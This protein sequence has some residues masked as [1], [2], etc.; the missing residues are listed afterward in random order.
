MRVLA[1]LVFLP[2]ALWAQS[3]LLIS[4]VYVP[5]SAQQ[6]NAFVEIYNPTDQSIDLGEYYL[7]NYNSAYNIVTGTYSTQVGDFLVKFPAGARI[8]SGESRVVALYG[9]A[10]GNAYSKQAHWEITAEDENTPDMDNLWVGGNISLDPS[11]G[12]IHLFKWNGQ[13]DLIRDVDYMA[14]GLSFFKER[15]MDKSGVSIDGPDAD[16]TATAYR[17]DTPKASQKALAT[18][19]AGMSYQRNGIV[20]VA[21]TATEGNGLTG[22]DET[23]E[24]WTQSFLAVSPSP[25]SFSEVAGDG[26][27]SAVVDPAS[28][29]ANSTVTL[30]F[31]LTGT[32]DYVLQQ[33]ALIIP[34]SWS[35]SGSSADVSYSGDGLAPAS[36]S[37]RGDTLFFSGTQLTD[38]Q[39]GTI[40]IA[41]LQ[42]PDKTENSA[43]E[44]RTAVSG[45]R[46][47]P[48][49]VFPVVS[50]VKA[51]TIAD[52]QNNVSTYLGTQVTI[53]GVVALG[54]GITTN[55]WTD[56]YVQDA[57]GRGINVFR[58]G[59]L[60]PQLKRGN[61]VTVS[62]TVDE[63]NGTTEIVDFTVTVDDSLQ[64]V[65]EVAFLSLAAAANI[66]L[67]GTMVEVNGVISDMFSAG[68]G[69]TLTI[70]NGGSTLSA[71]IWDN[72]G[73]DLS[74]YALGDTIAMR[75][76]VDIY[77]GSA[78][79]L[80]GYQED[81][82]LSDLVIPADG[83]GTVTV[84]PARVEPGASVDL[85]FTF[86]P[87]TDDTLSQ[88]TLAIPSGWSFSGSS[89]DVSTGG[90]FGNANTEVTAGLV[91]LSGF[92][93][94][95][96]LEGTLTLKNISAPNANTVSTFNIKTAQSGGVLTSIKSAPIVLVGSGTDIPTI[97]ISDARSL[98]DGTAISI[99]GVIVIGAGILRNDF[100]SA[101]IADEDGAG[102]NVFRRGSPD[103][104]IVRGNLVVLQGTLTSF[105]GTLEIENYTTTVL[106]K[107]YP[108]PDPLQLSTG[109]SALAR[110]EGSWV[111]VK[112]I[113]TGKSSAGGGTN[114]FI[115]DGS[116]ETTIR[117]W[118]TAG[119]NLDDFNVGDF[120]EASG[121]HGVFANAGQV[122]VG[123]QEDIGHI[124]LSNQPVSLKVPPR[125]FAP[126]QGEKLT[127]EY[128]SGGANT[129]VT[130]RI[131]DMNGRLVATLVDGDGIPLPVKLEWDGRNQVGDRLTVGA[132]V[133][134]FEVVD[135]D[136]GNRTTRVAP[137]VIGT[138]LSR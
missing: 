69:T 75:G 117:I 46:L 10:F 13:D 116:G 64:D 40:E 67:E 8:A 107:N 130:L 108:L 80:V 109:Q 51:L 120:I 99:K 127:I 84:S 60:V 76:I 90:V 97:S 23:S 48:I 101:Y 25:G 63:F 18:P 121:V 87:T 68:G 49:A 74:G 77:Q 82:Y 6:Q 19:A 92:E 119:L 104:D 65:P 95:G 37:I 55:S 111:H 79:L 137:I 53:Q 118:D 36:L 33:A 27:G 41:N 1:A 5:A 22:H 16:D 94:T 31:T 26:S 110:Y 112:G 20:E 3:H 89:A 45:G 85:L 125:P 129:R 43:F 138:I 134:H 122:L 93:L 34:A 115:D 11:A 30:T 133:L 17:N 4:E 103:P 39:T 54:S 42:T 50:V 102:L 32:A 57:S 128:G 58:T 28:L 135:K 38:T 96:G 136:T 73:V 100:T 132:Y 72:T 47:T 106:S 114:I 59:E 91:T 83:S 98:P 124:D 66:D 7:A 29:D 123:Y 131:Y 14:W 12:M 44:I 126:D 21:E 88:A 9:S 71:R 86:S 81:I 105:N 56:A 62:G 35:F 70:S 52:I 15:W 78:Q 24:D 2:L 113:V 61:L